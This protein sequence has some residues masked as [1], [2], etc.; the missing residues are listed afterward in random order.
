[1]KD[2]LKQKTTWAGLALVVTGIGQIVAEE[3]KSEG[4]GTILTGLALIFLRQSVA[5]A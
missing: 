5:K 4:I 2:M 1:M 3:N